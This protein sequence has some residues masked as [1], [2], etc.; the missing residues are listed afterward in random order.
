[1]SQKFLRFGTRGSKLA[2]TQTRQVIAALCTAHPDLEYEI[3][4][5][6][7]S[8][9]HIQDTPLASMPD[10]GV[11]VRE[12]ENALI[13][14]KIDVAVH[15]FKDLPTQQ[16][17]GLAIA[18]VPLR[19][20]PRDVLYSRDG[21]GIKELP[22]G[23][24]IGTSS[25]RRR[26]QCKY[27]RPDVTTAD[28]RGNVDTR[29]RKVREG[30]YDA[31]ILAAAGLARLSLLAEAS[32]IFSP[33]EMVP[34]PAQ[35]ALGIEIRRDDTGVAELLAAIDHPASRFAAIAERK[36]LEA[37]GSGCSLPLGAFAACERGQL[38]LQALAIEPDGSRRLTAVAHGPAHEAE[39]VGEQA[40]RMLLAQGAEQI[41]SMGVAYE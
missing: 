33:Q 7:T 9:D 27:L 4:I 31:T 5:I 11:F 17:E 12:I 40:A 14:G 20:D 10:T 28:I 23:A 2:L 13:G 34:A 8:G 24:T 22:A 30:L 19:Q 6:S 26:A 16:P 21:S 37:L 39:R 29:M 36:V 38:T 18:A 15:S 32:Y 3:K 35:G 1:M 25:T 41:L